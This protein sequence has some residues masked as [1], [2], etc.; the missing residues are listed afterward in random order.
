MMDGHPNDWVG[1]HRWHA[2]IRAAMLTGASEDRCLDLLRR[3]A[4]SWAIQTEADPRIDARDNPG[5]GQ[6]RIEELCQHWLNLSVEELDSAFVNN[7]KRAPRRFA[8]S[9]SGFF[10]AALDDGTH[11]SRVTEILENAAGDGDP[12]HSGWGRFWTLPL[13][14]FMG[15]DNVH[16]NRLIAPPGE[17]RG[18]NS[19]LVRIL[20]GR[21]VDSGN[22]PRMP[23]NRPPLADED[24]AYIERWID[25]G[26]N[27]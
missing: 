3:V 2:S 15:I 16:R 6:E 7:K 18:A 12:D 25:E 10:T 5:L 23:L 9:R 22:L 8:S 19:N 1:W 21:P 17:N 11:Y 26:C 24:I 20:K 4:L 13:D 14:Q 27:P